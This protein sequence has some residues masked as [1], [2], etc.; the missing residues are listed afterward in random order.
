VIIGPR[1]FDNDYVTGRPVAAI[2]MNGAE[3]T[4]GPH[5]V[6]LFP[7]EFRA[8]VEMAPQIEQLIESQKLLE[9][10]RYANMKASLQC[11][12]F[13][14]ITYVFQAWKVT[15]ADTGYSSGFKKKWR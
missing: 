14:A 5:V 6:F 3:G 4:R 15:Q 7:E 11:S 1:C 8:L 10:Q 13:L 12:Y 9:I 2:R